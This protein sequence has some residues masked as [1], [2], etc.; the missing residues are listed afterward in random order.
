MSG[1]VKS[2]CIKVC[3]YDEEEICIGCH[4]TMDD[5]TGWLFMTD[6]QKKKSL[7]AAAVRRKTPRPG[8]SN[9]DHYV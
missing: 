4:R 7:E 3:K 9:Y 5:I 8:K 2:P 6:D 1:T